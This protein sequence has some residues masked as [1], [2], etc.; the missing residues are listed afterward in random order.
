[1]KQVICKVREADP[2]RVGATFGRFLIVGG[3]STSVHYV[4]L[5]A[6]VELL[7][8][9]AVFGSGVGFAVGA[10]VSYFLNR[11]HTFRSDAPHGQAVMR[12]VIVLAVG[13]VLNLILMQWFTAHWGWPYLLAQMV[14]TVIVLFWHFAGHALWSFT[15]RKPH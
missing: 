13:L 2:R 8:R 5:A 11:R 3:I 10:V 4:V 9:S 1:M 12:F 14:T 7:H 6:V 15:H